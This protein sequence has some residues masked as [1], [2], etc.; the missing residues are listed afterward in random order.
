MQVSDSQS[1]PATASAPLSITVNTTLAQ[2]SVVTASLPAG[3]QNTAYSAMLA[4]TG[5]VTPFTW[6][7]TAGSLP[8]GLSLNNGTGAIT[9]APAGAGTANFTVKVTDSETPPATASAPLSITVQPVLPLSITTS[10]LPAGTAGSPY[11]ATVA[12]IGGVTPYT[13]SVISGKIPDGLTFNTATGAITGTPQNVG[14]S[15]LT[16]QVTDSETPP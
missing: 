6:S 11:S 13:W 14:T 7:V 8:G 9:G 12:A 2:L 15:N 10:S 1:P 16:F 3:T 5:G 4:A